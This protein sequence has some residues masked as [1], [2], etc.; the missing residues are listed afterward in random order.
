MS[1][2]LG[3]RFASSYG[4]VLY[5]IT[6]EDFTCYPCLMAVAYTDHRNTSTIYDQTI[7]HMQAVTLFQYQQLQRGL[8][9]KSSIHTVQ[10]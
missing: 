10:F 2:Y 1:R 9:T 3:R 6:S 5:K 4:T 8:L 7:Y